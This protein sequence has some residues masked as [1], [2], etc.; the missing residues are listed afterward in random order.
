MSIVSDL[1]RSAKEAD[2]QS[3]RVSVLLD[4]IIYE[5]SNNTDNIHHKQKR[6]LPSNV[7]VELR[8]CRSSQL[9]RYA[10]SDKILPV[11]TAQLKARRISRLICQ[12][13]ATVITTRIFDFASDSQLYVTQY[14]ELYGKKFGDMKFYFPDAIVVGVLE[15]KKSI[16]NPALSHRVQP[17]SHIILFRST[18]YGVSGYG[19]LKEPLMIK[20]TEWT[21][22][23]VGIGSSRDE[24][25]IEDCGCKARANESGGD[26]MA[27]IS[28]RHQLRGTRCS[29]SGHY[30]LPIEYTEGW[31]E[32][33]KPQRVLI[34]CWAEF[35]YM[36]NMIRELDHGNWALPR[37]SEVTLFN[38][39]SKKETLDLLLQTVKLTN[40]SVHHVQGDPLCPVSLET[41]DMSGYKT[42]LV[43][44]DESWQD[45]DND[46]TN[47][48]QFGERRDMLRLDSMIMMVQLNI[49]KQ[50]EESQ[51]PDINVI[52]WKL[53][54]EGVTR[55][56]DEYRLPMGI[57][58]NNSS[59]A[60]NMLAQV[61]FN[62]N[63]LPVVTQFGDNVEMQVIDSS[64][65]AS[66]GENLSFW[67]LSIRASRMSLVLIGYYEIPAKIE[68]PL[69]I[70]L[71]PMGQE[72]RSQRKVWNQSNGRVKLLTIRHKNAE[73]MKV[74]RAN[75]QT[76]RLE[77]QMS[78]T[79][80]RKLRSGYAAQVN[81][82]GYNLQSIS[83]QRE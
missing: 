3:I 26:M 37:G 80:Q 48:I 78:S 74:Q 69:K 82:N 40:I 81:V 24:I 62:P 9:V 38:N 2:A 41:I 61:G 51:H 65:I 1:S 4:E 63:I 68:D 8:E 30:M 36:G 56:E 75:Q 7:I 13:V 17:G 73:E 25:A 31:R 67:D 10:C 70:Q 53:A 57:S 35:N 21:P 29:P 6:K 79:E 72:I 58:F 14:P 77:D 23:P 45:P 54:H 64:V 55:F 15:K 33:S 44:C 12:P 43:L 76:I 27:G 46:I 59:Y 49:R 16:I 19:P 20:E 66:W 47:G 52:C 83:E 18:S 42:A 71:N 34:C 5:N 60:A 50:L 28:G 32:D 22:S 39:H 11:D